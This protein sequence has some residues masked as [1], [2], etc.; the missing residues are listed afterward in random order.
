M[1]RDMQSQ[2]IKML[3]GLATMCQQ[4]IIIE[5]TS[6]RQRTLDTFISAGATTKKRRIDREP[7][8]EHEAELSEASE[9]VEFSSEQGTGKLLLFD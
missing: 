2:N 9:E 4:T 5:D 7:S 1:F 6:Q 3:T 8:T